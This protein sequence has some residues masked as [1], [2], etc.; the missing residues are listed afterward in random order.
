MGQG[1]PAVVARA[2]G[3]KMRKRERDR[4][5]PRESNRESCRG[6]VQN[7]YIAVIRLQSSDL[8][9]TFFAIFHLLVGKHVCKWS[10]IFE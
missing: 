10:I 2:E 3:N 4:R 7:E 1:F 9:Q 8:L 6:S 5:E